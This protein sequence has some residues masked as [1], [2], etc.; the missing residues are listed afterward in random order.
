VEL[1]GLSFRLRDLGSDI[2]FEKGRVELRNDG[3]NLVNLEARVDGQGRLVIGGGGRPG[4]SPC[5]G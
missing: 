2:A 1:G 4:G 5:A 3:I